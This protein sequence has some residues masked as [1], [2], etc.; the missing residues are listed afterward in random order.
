MCCQVV[1]ELVWGFRCVLLAL[2]FIHNTC[3]LLHGNLGLHAIF[4][5]PSGDWKLG[6]MELAVNLTLA[7]DTEHFLKH[8]HLL[9]KPYSSPERSQL[10]LS[11]NAGGDAATAL[12]TLKAKVS[13]SFQFIAHSWAIYKY[14]LTPVSVCMFGAASPILHR[15]IRTRPVHAVGFRP[16]GHRD[17]VEPV[18]VSNTHGRSG[19]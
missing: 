18:Q 12:N 19:N 1:Q 6:S 3:G 13:N 16:A 5:S 11:S 9:G 2:G 10:P 4:V 8:Q 15:Y 14:L 7:D 17:T